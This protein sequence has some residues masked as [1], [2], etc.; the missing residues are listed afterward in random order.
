MNA[1]SRRDLA[2]MLALAAAYAVT[3]VV[4]FRLGATLHDMPPLWPAAGVAIA[5]LCIGGVGLWPGVALGTLI[6]VGPR[7]NGAVLTAAIVVSTTAEAVVAALLLTR[8]AKFRVD[9]HSVRDAS[10][11]V[12]IAGIVA[13][14]VGALIGA[15][16]FA[17][18]GA[19]PFSNFSHEWLSWF[20]GDGMGAIVFA[21]V[22]LVWTRPDRPLPN[23]RR[24]LELFAFIIGIAVTSIIALGGTPLITGED[25]PLIFIS[26]PFIVWG[27]LRLGLR[28]TMTTVAIVS[29]AASIAASMHRGVFG[30]NATDVGA[31]LQAYLATAAA[32]ALIVAASAAERRDVIDRLTESE[33]QLSLVV[34][35]NS[36]TLLLFSVDGVDEYRLLTANRAFRD[37]LRQYRPQVADRELSGTMMDDLIIDTLG[38]P[39]DRIAK[40]YET[41]RHVIAARIPFTYENSDWNRPDQVSEVTLVPVF[42]AS[43]RP[44]HILR[45]SRDISA[46]KHAENAL[47]LHDF[48]VTNAP[49]GVLMLDAE[50]RIVFANETACALLAKPRQALL[51]TRISDLDAP[52]DV[53]QWRTLEAVGKQAGQH[54]VE[55]DRVD[56]DGARHPLELSIAFLAYAGEEVSCVFVRDIAERRRAEATRRTLEAELFH[57]QKMEAIGTLAGGIAHDFNNILAAIVGNTEMAQSDLPAAHPSRQDLSEVL[58]ATRRAR[59][60]VSQIL[61]FSRKQQPERRPVRL[62]DVVTD[63]HRLLRAT[64]PSTIE[65]RADIT[66]SDLYVF[67]EPTQLHQVLM[68][69]C[70]NSAH[71]IGDRHGVIALRQT[72]E[73]IGTES[74]YTEL[75]PGRYACLTVSDTGH[76]MDRAT[77]ERAFEPFF[78]TKGP[79]VGT[80]LGLAV[81]HG[82]VRNHDGVVHVDST[83]GSGTMFRLYF[84]LL[85]A[86]F[87]ASTPDAPVIP[88]GT[89]ERVLFVDDEPSL[90]TL[91]RRMLERLGYRVLALRSATEAL[92]TFRADPMAFDLVISDLTMPD[93]TGSQL[94][95]ELHR[96]R[97]NLPVILSTGY[98]DRLDADTARALHVRELLI[99]P[100]TTEALA[101]AVQRALT[102]DAA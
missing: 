15:G 72:M 1:P 87:A 78:T 51:S 75:V 7:G 40:N 97:A 80:G 79:G 56:N 85:A 31:L 16:S 90:T 55:I 4:G 37:I 19:T 74:T 8:V 50:H 60:L 34:D 58:R 3:A 33:R 36:D 42:D 71:A 24:A 6:A 88:R 46:R 99:K 54:T 93:L 48:V 76:G 23:G 28:T 57:A 47:R 14:A 35:S 81:V 30:G 67:G 20:L 9:L 63:V 22:V 26:F 11:L 65:L 38:L 52:G 27:A 98:L 25:R 5:A 100:Y 68:N 66:D 86:S 64:I 29:I 73:E 94:A 84:P 95:V 59:D 43:G 2:R 102:E 49:L 89:G 45:S 39:P 32:T 91:T 77:L 82:I 13:P 10:M 18:A 83:P 12:V 69:L 21:P 70:T 53:P 41:F 44:T 92:A 17:L 62:S 96:L 61:T 101:T